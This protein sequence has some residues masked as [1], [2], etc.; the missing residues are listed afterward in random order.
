MV[1]DEFGKNTSRICQRC[2][3]SAYLAVLERCSLS[4]FHAAP[5]S[6][7]KARLNLCQ[8]NIGRMPKKQRYEH[9]FFVSNRHWLSRN[10]KKVYIWSVCCSFFW[11]TN[12]A[13]YTPEKPAS[14]R[15]KIEIFLDI[16]LLELRFFWIS[17]TEHDAAPYHTRE[18]RLNGNVANFYIKFTEQ[19][20][21]LPV[22]VW[23]Y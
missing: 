20:F 12:A 6:R 18:P 17:A 5:Y 10:V 22:K 19:A 14:V 16:L 8:N 2:K 23:H 7:L 13:P 11:H 9:V 15:Q 1:T 3:K 21:S 4:L